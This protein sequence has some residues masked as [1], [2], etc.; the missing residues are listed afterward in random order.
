MSSAARSRKHFSQAHGFFPALPPFSCAGARALLSL[1]AGRSWAARA[2]AAAFSGLGAPSRL[3]ALLRGLP[4]RREQRHQGHPGSL[5]SRGPR[6]C[7]KLAGFTKPAAKLVYSTLY[8]SAFAV[9]VF[10]AEHG[11]AQHASYATAS[12]TCAAPRHAKATR[13]KP[14]GASLAQLC[15]WAPCLQSSCHVVLFAAAVDEQARALPALPSQEAYA[16]IPSFAQGTFYG[17]R[18]AGKQKQEKVFFYLK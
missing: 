8:G 6:S 13:Q 9:G 16:M 17:R 1:W 12:S 14:V 2:I 5:L 15:R 7:L 10:F 11:G 3:Q 4:G 18:N